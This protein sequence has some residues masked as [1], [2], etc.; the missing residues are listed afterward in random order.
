MIRPQ[1]LGSRVK[2]FNA[3]GAHFLKGDVGLF[4][5]PFFGI[6]PVEAKVESWCPVIPGFSS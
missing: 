5:A 4:D 1:S 3:K 2:Q 6:P